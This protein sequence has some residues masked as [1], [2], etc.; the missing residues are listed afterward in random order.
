MWKLVFS[1]IV[2]NFPCLSLLIAQPTVVPE[3]IACVR[4]IELNFFDEQLVSE[5][6]GLY[7]IQQQLWAP[8]SMTLRMKSAEIPGRMKGRTGFLVPNPLEYPMQKW[9][10][11]AIL[12]QVLFEIFLETMTT[13]QVNERPNADF[14][15]DYI[16]SQ[17]LPR[18][19]NCFGEE[20]RRLQQRF[21]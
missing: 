15:F 16:F 17:Q 4:D 13:Y 8:I 9:V 5:A 18:F 12:K 7:H 2:G 14:V 19:I 20:A 11:A 6:L 10:V 1:L 3:P 21:D